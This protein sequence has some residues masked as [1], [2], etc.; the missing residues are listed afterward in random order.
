MMTRMARAVLLGVVVFVGSSCD[1]LETPSSP[2]TTA[3]VVTVRA[4]AGTLSIGGSRFYSFNVS[5]EGRVS[6]MLAAV[7]S[8]TSGAALDNPLEIGLGV[9][10]GTGCRT[11]DA[12]LLEAALT[13]QIQTTTAP[14]TYC[15]RIAD[16]GHLRTTVNFAIRFSHP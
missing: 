1:N 4:F 13:S 9:P 8:P 3:A 5:Q 10:A 6:V 14:G 2:T 12:R 16:V 7:S 15:V 11:N